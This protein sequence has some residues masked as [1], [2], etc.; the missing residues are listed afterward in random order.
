MIKL[1]LNNKKVDFSDPAA[2]VAFLAEI[3]NLPDNLEHSQK[4]ETLSLKFKK[5]LQGN[6]ISKYP[7]ETILNLSSAQRDALYSITPLP[8]DF[9]RWEYLP[10]IVYTGNPLLAPQGTIINHEQTVWVIDTTTD[11]TFLQSLH[12]HG[13][14]SVEGLTI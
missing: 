9:T 1:L 11:S 6:A 14:L 8:R 13:A 2:I 12:D 3:E 7:V 5:I 10:P 4:R